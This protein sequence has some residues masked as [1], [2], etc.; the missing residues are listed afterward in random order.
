MIKLE[1]DNQIVDLLKKV[2]KEN[3]D[4]WSSYGNKNLTTYES[5]SSYEVPKKDL[6][7][8]PC[9]VTISDYLNP[10]IVKVK[11]HLKADE[12]TNALYMSPNSCMFWHTN[13]DKLGERIY[14]TF[15]TGKSVFKYKDKQ[16]N[17][18]ED[19]EDKGWNARS[20]IID[21]ENLFW[22]CVWTEGA[23]FS[24]GFSKVLS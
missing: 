18:I 13:S 22:H 3:K 4:V 21:K 14:Y 17:L 24:F 1:V 20:F 11:E 10:N 12:C 16:G 23:R 19:K 2:I 5:F 7:K 9:G 6:K 8:V 15:S